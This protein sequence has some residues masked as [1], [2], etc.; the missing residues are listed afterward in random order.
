M[1]YTIWSLQPWYAPPI[2]ITH[3]RLVYVR[4]RRIAPIT[5][6]VP[7]ASM[8]NIS[9]DGTSRQM[10]SASLTSYSCNRPVTGPHSRSVSVTRSST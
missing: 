10:S 3:L 6:S 8:R 7:E 1:P 9:T 4:A 5:P 2:L